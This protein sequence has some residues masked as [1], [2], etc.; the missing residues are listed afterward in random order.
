MTFRYIGSKARVVQAIAA[1]IGAPPP[2]GGRFVDLFC[3]TGVVA[4]AAARLGW[5][6]HLNDQLE[7]AVVMAAARLI[8]ADQACF[9]KFGGYERTLAD[10]NNTPPKLGFIHREY[11]PAS[12]ARLGFERRYFTTENAAKIDGIRTQIHHW[13]N[14]VT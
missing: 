4:E 10:L 1:Q 11:S 5:S 3:G 13:E 12:V 2:G 9:K 6:V 14:E 8:S 7:S